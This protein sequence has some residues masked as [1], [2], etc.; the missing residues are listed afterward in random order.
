MEIKSTA[1]SGSWYPGSAKECE[2]SVQGFLQFGSDPGNNIGGIVPH[3]GWVY[4]GAIACRV[5]ASLVSQSSI[6]D[7]IILFGA[8]MHPS[9]PAFLLDSGAVDT[10]LGIIEAD[11][12]LATIVVNALAK[13]GQVIRALSPG[14]FPDE[15]TLE[16][17]FA[18]IRYF[19]PNARILVCGV[20]PSDQA[21]RIGE[22]VV[23]GANALGRK[24]RIIGSTDMTHYGP[25]FG[26]EP[27]GEGEAALDWVRQENDA[28]AV[29][30][31]EEMDVSGIIAQGLTNHNMC[32]SGAAAAAVAACKKMGVVKGICLDYAT[33]YEISRS[34]SFVG[35]CGMVYPV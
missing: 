35:Y 18:F 28:R 3:A 14:A 9:S 10:P 20:P 34:S 12:E 29:R 25:N 32:C 27:A 30:A 33:S 8:H 23:E 31:L 15:N 6:P 2:K 26:F 7:T 1:F 17:Q 24:I 4:S 21:V 13:Q 11:G 16:L 5:I 19:F 22:A